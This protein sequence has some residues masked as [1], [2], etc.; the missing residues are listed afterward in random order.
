MAW[1]S[2][3]QKSRAVVWETSRNATK[4]RREAY[5]PVSIGDWKKAGGCVV[6]EVKRRY[7][8]I[9]LHLCKH[10]LQTQALMH[11]HNPTRSWHLC[12]MFLAEDVTAAALA[13]LPIYP[14][15]PNS[16][17]HGLSSA[18]LHSPKAHRGLCP[19]HRSLFLTMDAS[20]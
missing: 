2:K 7:T 4:K 15:F 12:G 19:D 6:Q 8:K 9:N 5:F 18:C 20:P 11:T 14:P 13:S 1:M 10:M 3:G 17:S 16:F